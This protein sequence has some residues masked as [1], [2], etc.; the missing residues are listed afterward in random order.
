METLEEFG[1]FVKW[2]NDHTSEKELTDTIS[3][4]E[5]SLVKLGLVAITGYAV[6]IWNDLKKAELNIDLFLG[7]GAANNFRAWFE[8][9]RK[10]NPSINIEDFVNGAALMTKSYDQFGVNFVKK[11]AQLIQG[12]ALNSKKSAQEVISSMA[13]FGDSGDLSILREAGILTAQQMD[14]LKKFDSA[15]FASKTSQEKLAWLN[16]K[17]G[18]NEKQILEA[19]ARALKTLVGQMEIFSSN[20][21]SLA[22]IFYQMLEPVLMR[23]FKV[24]NWFLDLLTNNPIGKFVTQTAILTL[25]IFGLASA[26]VGATAMVS[27][28]GSAIWVTLAALAPI[29]GMIV[30]IALLGLAVED[31]YR[32][33]KNPANDTFIGPIIEKV[34]EFN[35]WLD[36]ISANSDFLKALILGFKYLLIAANLPLVTIYKLTEVLANGEASA[37]FNGLIDGAKEFFDWLLKI[38]EKIDIL[39]EFK[40]VKGL[41]EG[42]AQGITAAEG[43][44]G[45]NVFDP[46]GSLFNFDG[47]MGL[48]SGMGYLNQ[49]SRKAAIIPTQKTEKQ[50]IETKSTITVEIKGLD[51][52]PEAQRAAVAR[53]L[54]DSL[55]EQGERSH[56]TPTYKPEVAE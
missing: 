48:D 2:I 16:I 42:A 55:K 19:K 22:D 43:W 21:R 13:S 5:D 50:I 33:F 49:V 15:H 11:N 40:T 54:K 20:S 31:L 36:E 10:L 35:K 29:A 27:L 52:I 6:H 7:S 25:G 3:K 30:L 39:P 45:E 32:Y 28:F 53:E 47:S 1:V 18:E 4:I 38:W 23:V 17:L 12:I 24:F 34:K 8:E 41:A 26:F 56:R 9:E 44:M 51:S 14:R 46:V 37:F